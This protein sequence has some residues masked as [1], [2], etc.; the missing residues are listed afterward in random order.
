MGDL[1][2]SWLDAT[3]AFR[4]FLRSHCALQLALEKWAAFGLCECLVG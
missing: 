1:F 3:D 4:S 2:L